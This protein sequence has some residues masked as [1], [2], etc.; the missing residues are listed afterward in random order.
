VFELFIN[1][2]CFE[3]R[4]KRQKFSQIVNK[5][6]LRSLASTACVT[7]SSSTCRLLLKT[8]HSAHANQSEENVYKRL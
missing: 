1:I 4:N 3:K 8:D 2:F 5:S 7:P 6:N